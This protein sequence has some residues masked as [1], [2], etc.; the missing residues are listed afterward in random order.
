MKKSH[1][2]KVTKGFLTTLGIVSILGFVAI[3][4]NT[5]FNFN[6]LSDNVESL[7]FVILGVGLIVEGQVLLWKTMAKDGINSNELTHIVTGV[8]GLVSVAV[9]LMSLF[10]YSSLVLDGIKGVVAS[11]AV[12]V[13]IIQVWLVK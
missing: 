7:M 3:V 6:W 8:I 1:K 5:W 13:I 10:G 9:G 4:T 11:I 2:Q 12:I